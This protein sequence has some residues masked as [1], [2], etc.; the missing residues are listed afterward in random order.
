MVDKL[1]VGDKVRYSYIRSTGRS[2]LGTPPLGTVGIVRAIYYDEGIIN[3]E[4]ETPFSG[5]HDCS[6]DCAGE[7]GLHF[8]RGTQDGKWQIDALERAYNWIK[9]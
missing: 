6:G 1:K 8:Y 9:L 2:P 4:F 3:V 7:K 5:G